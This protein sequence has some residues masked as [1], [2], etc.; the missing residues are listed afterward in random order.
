MTIIPLH[1]VRDAAKRDALMASMTKVGWQGRPILAVRQADG[2][3]MAITG[4]HR[5]DA[6]RR[7]GVTPDVLIIDDV[8]MSDGTELSVALDACRDDDDRLRVLR[9]ADAD[10]DAVALM[11]AEIE[12]E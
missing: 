1:E 5:I 10:E 9:E 4:S 12:A 8:T 2:A 7:V 3:L 6:A 11:A